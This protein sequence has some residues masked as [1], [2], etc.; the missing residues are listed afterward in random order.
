MKCPSCGFE[1]TKDVKFCPDCGT[2]IEVKKEKLYVCPQCKGDVTKDDKFCPVCGKKIKCVDIDV[3]NDALPK[4]LFTNAPQAKVIE[5][6]EEKPTP[7]RESGDL[8]PKITKIVC[9]SVIL[10]LLLIMTIGSFGTMANIVVNNYPGSGY[11]PLYP[12][13]PSKTSSLNVDYFFGGASGV[14]SDAVSNSSSY[15]MVLT[16]YIF[17]TIA[18][19]AQI[20]LLTIASINLIISCIKTFVF[21][22]EIRAKFVTMSAVTSLT[23]VAILKAFLSYRFEATPYS[24]VGV[25]VRLGWG[26]ILLAVASSLLLLTLFVYKTI[27]GKQ[28]NVKYILSKFFGFTAALLL[29]IAICATFNPLVHVSSSAAGISEYH[30]MTYLLFTNNYSPYSYVRSSVIIPLWIGF[31]F[32]LL[33]IGSLIAMFGASMN[34]KRVGVYVMG[35]ISLVSSIVSVATIVS[36]YLANTNLP[37]DSSYYIS[38]SGGYICFVVLVILAIGLTIPS[39]ILAKKARTNRA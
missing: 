17:L 9:A 16:T 6:R 18:F 12:Y 30:G 32:G 24:S 22:K 15:T 19:I 4:D 7:K 34:E 8:M 35:G 14:L 27:I 29:L 21:G 20:V 10:F 31:A 36:V 26:P 33:T 38:L 37:Y 39:A 25:S 28:F 5:K 23:Y 13:F 2:K 11:N 3:E 1:I